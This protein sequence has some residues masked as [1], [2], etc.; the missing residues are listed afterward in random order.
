MRASG[1]RIASL[2]A[3][4]LGAT[5]VGFCAFAVVAWAMLTPVIGPRSE[6]GLGW[7]TS[8][9]GSACKPDLTPL[10]RTLIAHRSELHEDDFAVEAATVLTMLRGHGS[11]MLTPADR[12]E[13]E[14]AAARCESVLHSPCAGAKFESAVARRCT[15]GLVGPK[16]KRVRTDSGSPTPQ[17]DGGR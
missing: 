2:A 13:L 16:S 6:L 17:R 7:V 4:H 15:D 11:E 8:Q 9:S 10:A 5:T 12:R 14:D 3:S 1:R